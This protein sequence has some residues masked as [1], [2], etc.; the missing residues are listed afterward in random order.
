MELKNFIFVKDDVIPL[1][2]LSSLLKWA[3]KESESFKDAC[4]IGE[5]SNQVIDSTIRKVKNFNL[6][7]NSKFKTE[8]HWFNFLKNS[9][10]QLCI[11]YQTKYKVDL[12]LTGLSEIS[13]LKYENYGHY[14]FHTDH[15]A[16]APRTM[17]IVYLLNNDYDGGNLVFGDHTSTKEILTIERFP[18]RAI[19]WPS[20]FL[21][22]HKVIPITKGVRYSIVSWAL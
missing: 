17:T 3:N 9:F 14:K 5:N 13:I 4:I 7:P 19:I 12:C 20:N 11:E 2:A 18:N 22:P 16:S 1:S 21:F 8:I 15:H 10:Q 6:N